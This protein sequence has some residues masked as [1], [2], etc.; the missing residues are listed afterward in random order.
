MGVR[1]TGAPIGIALPMAEP[2]GTALLLLKALV[3]G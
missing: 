1:L 3:F 2:M